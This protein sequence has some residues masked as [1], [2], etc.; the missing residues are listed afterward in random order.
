MFM[1]KSLEDFLGDEVEPSAR[2][3]ITA[4]STKLENDV[5]LRIA[6]HQR[7]FAQKDAKTRDELAKK[8][9]ASTW[10]VPHA[11]DRRKCPACDNEGTVTG[12]LIKELPPAWIDG[13]LQV[14]QE[15]IATAFECPVCELSLKSVEEVSVAGLEPRFT[16]HRVTELHELYEP[17]YEQEYDNM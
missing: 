12:K 4:L 15:F 3:M 9:A 7:V 1:K 16:Q 10:L 6:A 2:Q 14:D 13:S 17:D 5:K 11:H 8:G